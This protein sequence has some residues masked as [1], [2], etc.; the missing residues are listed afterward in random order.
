METRLRQS[1]A[2]QGLMRLFGAEM[3]SIAPGQ[4]E[5]SLEPKPEL[6]QQ[7]GFIHGGALTAIADSA[8]GYAALSLMPANRGVLTTEMKICRRGSHHRARQGAEGWAHA[9][10][11]A[12]GNLHRH[13]RSGKVDRLPDRHLHDHRK[14]RWDR[15]L[16][17]VISSHPS[18]R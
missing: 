17:R 11:G 15:R 3:T 2:K 4:V 9:E 18:A 10:P 14:S 7:H 8:A 12:D 13:R 5:I 1:F 6:S 16:N